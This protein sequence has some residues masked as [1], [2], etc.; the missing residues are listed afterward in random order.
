[1][2]AV[3]SLMLVFVCGACDEGST[4]LEGLY[5]VA[6]W[7]INPDGCDVEGGPSPDGEL[8]THFFVRFDSFF[9]EEFVTAV[10]CTD[11]DECRADAAATGTFF[12]GAWAFDEGS[13]DDGWTGGRGLLDDT[14][15]GVVEELA[16]TGAP[17]AEVRIEMTAATISDGPR[18]GDGCELAG[19]RALAAEQP[20]ESL[21]VVVGTY[22]EAI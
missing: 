16:L 8:Y 2:R 21:E 14:C 12:L 4:E 15:S 22:L 10:L 20:C 6:S 17:A 1:M 3:L 13:D 7:T 18:D 19:A 5:E 9:G 11:V